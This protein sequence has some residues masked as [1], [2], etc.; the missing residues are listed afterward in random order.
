[1]SKKRVAVLFG[2]KSNEYS[3]SLQS[4]YAVLKN[5]KPEGYEIYPIGITQAGEWYYYTGE[6]EN[7]KKDKWIAD[8]KNCTP[9]LLSPDTGHK[10][11]LLFEECGTKILETDYIFPV[12]H[13]KNGEDG[14]VQGL[15]LLTGIPLVGCNTLASALCMDKDRSHKL[16][17]CAGVK[18]PQAVVLHEYDVKE[19]W[20]EIAK[21][22]PY[23]RFVK[24]VKSG[25]SVG[26]SK[27]DNE[28]EMIAAIES[29]L[30][31]DDEVIV[32]EEIDGFEVGCA[33]LGNEEV[34]IGRVDEIELKQ[35]FFDFTEKYTLETAAIHMPA[36][37]DK[38][39]EE[40][41]KETA[42]KIYHTLGCS[43]FARVDMFLTSKKEIVFNEVNT[44][45]G[46]TEH[47]RYPNMM[48]GIGLNFSEILDKLIET[49]K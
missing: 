22:L 30:E 8:T 47:S 5:L 45:P 23:P 27:V 39:T 41:I 7:I 34:L 11:I 26:V 10:G 40:K 32:E 1:M 18:V 29:A 46:F 2:G 28:S 49:A 37:I 3:I 12:L 48:A 43:G 16:V 38:E 13:G 14:S 33:V 35:G 15:V 25:S 42:E 20:A 31:Y 9:A 17:E 36:R 19:T 4:S 24:P 21:E 44:I 6:I